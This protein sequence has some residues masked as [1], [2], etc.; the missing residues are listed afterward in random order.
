MYRLLILVMPLLVSATSGAMPRSNIPLEKLALSQKGSISIE[1]ISIGGL[2]I[3]MSEGE[4]IKKLGKPRSRR[5]APNGCTGTN[6]LTLEYPNL[7]LY[8]IDGSNEKEKSY[9]TA[10]RTTNSRYITNRRIRVGDSMIKAEKAYL[11][12]AVPT[13]KE[14]YLSL[15]DPKNNECNLTF[16]SSNGRTVSEI[17]LVCA[18]C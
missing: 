5:I 4:V 8:L 12:T 9:L 17:N 7:G 6:D 2:K 11:K 1:Q 10:I 3:G 18:V 15:T 13:K 16:S 14:L